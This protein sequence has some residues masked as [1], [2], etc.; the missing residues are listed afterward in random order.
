MDDTGYHYFIDAKLRSSDLLFNRVALQ[1]LFAKALRSFSV[2]GFLDHKFGEGGGV[3]GIF[4]LA[5]SHCSYHTY[6]E[7]RYIAID[8]FTCGR[9]PSE[10]ILELLEQLD[11]EHHVARYQGRG[12]SVIAAAA[13]PATEAVLLEG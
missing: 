6:P 12:S 3:T 2:I 4:L 7:S 13:P 11:C 1:Q 10:V 9:E 8:V 5:E